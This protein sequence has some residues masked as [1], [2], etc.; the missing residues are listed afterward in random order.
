MIKYGVI[1]MDRLCSD[2]ENWE[3]LYCAGR[4]HKPTKVLREDSRVVLSQQHN[5]LGAMRTALLMLP[6]E[7]TEEELFL[8]ITG[9]SYM[10]LD[11]VLI[12]LIFISRRL[13]HACV[14]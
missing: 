14:G 11:V 1:S 10:G 12:A 5:L 7:F 4:F 6:A 8:K 3:T 13:S 9:L 2:L